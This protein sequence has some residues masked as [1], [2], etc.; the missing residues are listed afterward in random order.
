MTGYQS[1]IYCTQMSSVTVIGNQLKCTG[2]LFIL[3]KMPS[4]LKVEPYEPNQTSEITEELN[5]IDY[6]VPINAYQITMELS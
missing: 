4:D 2:S 3:R 5:T 1:L 6:I